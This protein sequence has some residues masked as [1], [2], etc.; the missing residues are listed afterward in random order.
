MALRE[1]R[2][3]TAAR[4]AP[5]SSS[6]PA[7]PGRARAFHLAYWSEAGAEKEALLGG[8]MDFLLRAEILRRAP[9]PAGATG[10]SKIARG[11][12]SRALV[13]VCAENHG[14]GKRLLRVRCAMRLSRLGA[15]PVARLCGARRQS[16]DPRLADGGGG[17]RRRPGSSISAA[18]GWQLAG[19][20]PADAAHHRGR[21]QADRSDSAGAALGRRIRP[22]RRSRRDAPGRPGGA[23]PGATADGTAMIDEA[24]ALSARPIAGRSPGPWRRC[25]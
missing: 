19:F 10:T 14:G 22:A 1:M 23:E 3:Q 16:P 6:A 12:C 4:L 11:L 5:R 13:M 17:D 8:L 9:I 20:R 2:A 21:R 18:I 25:F 7:S 15:V 24:P